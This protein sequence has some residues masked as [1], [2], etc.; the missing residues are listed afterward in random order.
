ML[1]AVRTLPVLFAE[2]ALFAVQALLWIGVVCAIAAGGIAEARPLLSPRV[3]LVAKG[4]LAA[5]TIGDPGAPKDDR[6][7]VTVRVPGGAKT[8]LAAGFDARTLDGGE[9]AAVRAGPE[10][11]ARLA[12]LPG[13]ISIE[14]RRILRTL[15]D[16]A[17]P[18][19]HAPE[20]R[21]E[22]GLDGSGVLVGLVDTGV[23]V[24][25]ADLRTADGHTRVAALLDLSSTDGRHPE[26]AQFGG[27]VWTASE[28]DAAL[29]AEAA[30]MT[31]QVPVTEK[32]RDGHGTHVAAIAISDGLATARG[33]PAGRYVGVAPG[34]ELVAVQATHGGHTFTDVDVLDGCRFVAAEA[35]AL[36]RPLVLSLSL[37]G[38]GGAHDGSTSLEEGLDSLF[39]VAR[40]GRVLVVAAGNDGLEDLHAGGWDASGETVV[41]LATSHATTADGTIAIELWYAGALSIGVETP[42]GVRSPPVAVG[43]SG[44]TS[45]KEGKIVVDDASN[46][47][48]PDG[49]RSASVTLVG[50]PGASPPEGTWKIHLVGAA[51]RWDAYL[52]D[53][54]GSASFPRFTDHVS[55]DDR[56]SL[57]ATAHDAITVGSFISRNQWTTVDGKLEHFPIAIG[58]PSSFSSPG[59]TADGRFA[60][61]LLAPGE[62]VAAALSADAPPDQPGSAFFV[63][64]APTLAWAD[65]GLH[66]ILR[67]TSQAAPMVAG[68][69]AL[70]LQKDP[71]LTGD[72]VRE[73]LRASARPLEIGLGYSPRTGFGALDVLSAVRLAG[74]RRGGPVSA[75]LSTVGVSRD[76]LPPGD[77]QTRVTVTPRDASGAPLGPGRAV[78]IDLSAGAPAGPVSDA[79]FGRYE[80]DFLAH[81][82]RGAVGTVTAVVDGVTLTARPRVFFVA[83]RSEIG[84]VAG[85]GGCATGGGGANAR[86]AKLVALA[87]AL[88]LG[89]WLRNSRRRRTRSTLDAE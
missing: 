52:L 80:R 88:L 42:S 26:L 23:D 16:Q 17:G 53:A 63:A 71:Q 82:P 45:T 69:A 84:R 75:A 59:P 43:Q 5:R 77:E 36:G 67:G 25:H 39:P 21:K 46:G 86:S 34:A 28:I 30:G 20:A 61:D 62:F 14:E 7:L 8:L 13:V 87:L 33:L 83:D 56:L 3:R 6:A 58:D 74:G 70:L 9:L 85:V 47:P 12:A 15:L 49:L 41:P 50:P 64:G 31:P 10:E 68:A 1:L 65:D 11:L 66:G 81:A 44:T 51:S 35:D 4:A 32:D 38:R 89:A 24:R 54:P 55:E 48:R 18:A 2:R 73:I 29:A 22:S 76:A 57:P 79:G 27:A 60:P 40:N 78:S 19:V 72:Q 37:G